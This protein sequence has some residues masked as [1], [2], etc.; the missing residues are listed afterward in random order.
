M[1]NIIDEL[2]ELKLQLRGTVD[3]LLSFRNR[4][5]EYDSD[6]I[7]RLYSLEVEINKYSNIPDSEKTL[8]YQ[9]L[10]AG[11]DEFKQKIEEVILGIDSAI[12]KH[13]SSLIESG[14]KIDRCSEECPQDLKFTLSTLR[15][16]YNENLEVFFGMKKIYQKYL[17]NI[18]EKLKLV[19]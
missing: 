11:C 14:E 2:R 19:Y 9:N 10:I 17:K 15:Q 18:D 3:E 6:F 13:T 1:Q 8:I 4:L 16:V 7:G 5:S 12:R